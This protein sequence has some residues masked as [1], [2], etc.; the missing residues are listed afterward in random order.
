MPADEADPPPPVILRDATSMRRWTRARRREGAAV[1]FVPTMAS[2]VGLVPAT[3]SSGTDPAPLRAPLPSAPR[4]PP[5]LVSSLL[6]SPTPQGALHAGHLALLPLARAAAVPAARAAGGPD[7]CPPPGR[8]VVVASVYV[9]PT[10]FARGGDFDTYRRDETGDIE[11]LRGAGAD[12]VFLPDPGT[13]YARGA[14]APAVGPGGASGRAAAAAPP[15][16]GVVDAPAGPY[17]GAGPAGDR[18]AAP[19][20]GPPPPRFD[21]PGGRGGHETWVCPGPLAAGLDGASRPGHFRGVCTVVMKLLGAVEPDAVC[22]GKK[23]FQQWRVL[24]RCLRDLDCGAVVVGGE[25][26]RDGRDGLALS[27]RN[28][29][30]DRGGGDGGGDGGDG[31]EGD[32]ESGPRDGPGWAAGSARG[33][34]G[35]VPRALAACAA[36][37]TRGPPRGAAAEQSATEWIAG[38]EAAG[39]AAIDGALDPSSPGEGEGGGEGG[40]EGAAGSGKR[41]RERVEY[42]S[43]RCAAE[44][45][46]LGGRGGG[47]PD[48][49]PDGGWSGAPASTLAGRAVVVLACAVVGGVRLIDNV[50]AVVGTGGWEGRDE[51]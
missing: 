1:G 38:L 41:E 12:A 45:T 42:F 43:V 34:A 22:L 7:A 28:A 25:T 32:A 44:L 47:D 39:R 6:D 50:E 11:A 48:P 46:P 13:F 37:L 18:S 33:R 3:P 5:Y 2:T 16:A 8:A 49:D 40:G 20:A 26:V 4:P 30:L 17:G 35:A 29:G 19:W 14:G 36:A 10:Q 21:P 27:S 9:N 51:G 15:S 23:D 24:E 31:G